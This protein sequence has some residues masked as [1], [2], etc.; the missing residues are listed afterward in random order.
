MNEDN[1]LFLVSW[2][3]NGIEAVVNLTALERA[4]TWNIL[5]DQPPIKWG[6]I[7]NPI[8]L[9][10]R[11]NSHRHYEIYTFNVVPGLTEEDIREMFDNAPQA[12]ADLI[13]ERGRKIHSDRVDSS[14]VK[15]V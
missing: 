5:A 9:R 1:E 2:D 12:A 15:I 4:E 6:S 7:I 8:I 3:C 14:K 11:Y 10:A 13:R